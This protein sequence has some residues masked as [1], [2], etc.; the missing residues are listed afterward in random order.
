VLFRSV[1]MD[2]LLIDIIDAKRKA[3]HAISVWQCTMETVKP[4]RGYD[5][6]PNIN[7]FV[8]EPGHIQFATH[9]GLGEYDIDKIRVRK[10]EV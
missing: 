7:R 10:V 5:D 4:G 8:R 2:R 9:F 1:A 3:E 6:N